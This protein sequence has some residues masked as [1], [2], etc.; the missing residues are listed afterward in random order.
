M[1][2]LSSSPALERGIAAWRRLCECGPLRLE[3]LARDTGVPK[4]S[5]LRHLDTLASLGLICRDAPDKRF[6]ATALIVPLA[7]ATDAFSGR[8]A[9][10]LQQL[11]AETG[12]TAEW[13]VPQGRAM[14]LLLQ[15]FPDDG[16]VH[17]RAR[18]GFVRPSQGE[19]E[20]V[21]RAALA[22]GLKPEANDDGKW[23]TYDENGEVLRLSAKAARQALAQAATAQA[24]AADPCVNPNGVRR[25]AAAVRDAA[26]ALLGVLAIAESYS[27][28]AAARFARNMVAVCAAAARLQPQPTAHVM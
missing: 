18:V 5:L 26:G 25:H 7:A 1:A 28:G 9:T 4:A 15:R 8:L 3:E 14:V 24:S 2:T 17:V 21:L 6:R 23:W 13:W 19:L 20:A 22:A 27:P 16:E 10:A 12:H 11:C